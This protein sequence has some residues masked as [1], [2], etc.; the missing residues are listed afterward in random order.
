[1]S[2]IWDGGPKGS[3][4]R[5]VLI[6]LADNA[7]DEG[8]CWPSICTIARKTGLCE[9]AVRQ[10]L[11]QLEADGWLVT[12]IGGGRGGANRY[13]INPAPHA[14]GTT[15]PPAPDAPPPRH[16]VPPPPAPR[17]PEPSMNRQEEPS[18]FLFALSAPN[19]PQ[20]RFPDFWDQYPHRNGAKKGKAAAVKAWAR[21]LKARAS[22]EQIIAG[23]M[24]YAND[25]QV[26]QGYAKDPA[27]W[28]NAKGWEDEIEQ[29]H[30]NGERRTGGSGGGM[31]A[32]FAAVA[33][34]RAS[35]PN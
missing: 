21:A 35:R 32:A 34:R 9:R 2:A 8:E 30:G 17:A 10:A 29:P 6:A 14:P 31:V 27:T 13:T 25:R 23:A 33:A 1:M 4:L 18:D 22:P 24:R 28:L 3:T 19:E 15:C 11:R 20:D 26:V 7:N 16:H 5:F 12:K